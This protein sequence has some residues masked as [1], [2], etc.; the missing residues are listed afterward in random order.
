MTAYGQDLASASPLA[1]SLLSFN[2]LPTRWCHP[3]NLAPWADAAAA[4]QAGQEAIR[5]F[6]RQASA[7]FLRVRQPGVVLSLDDPVLPVFLADDTTF[8]RLLRLCGLVVLGPAIRRVIVRDEVR[9]LQDAL[10]PE[11]LAFTRRVAPGLWPRDPAAACEVLLTPDEVVDQVAALGCGL[12]FLAAQLAT[13]PVGARALLRLPAS[14]EDDV[15]QLPDSL[16]DRQVAAQV[17]LGV[18]GHLD[19][20]WLSVFPRRH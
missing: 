8:Q 12:L 16:G 18:L 15:L 19:A 6:H 2:L 13:P 1:H 5:R 10:D 11:E 3:S 14:A 20:S 7:D 4:L 17:V 9:A